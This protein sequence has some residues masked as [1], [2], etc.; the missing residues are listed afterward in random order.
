MPLAALVAAVVLDIASVQTDRTAI[1]AASVV[2]AAHSSEAQ[3]CFDGVSVAMHASR[4][5][6]DRAA[7][8]ALAGAADSCTQV[9]AYATG[10]RFPYD[11]PD[12]FVLRAGDTFYGYSTNSGAGDIQ[13]I[14][15][16]DLANWELVGNALAA[17]PRLGSPQHDVGAGRPA[18]RRWLRRVLHG[19]RGGIPATVHLAGGRCGACRAVPRRLERAA[20]VP[21]RPRGLDRSEPVRR[22]RRPRPHRRCGLTLPTVRAA[23]APATM[24]GV[25]E[26]LQ[27]TRGLAIPLDEIE[28]RFDTSGGPGGQHANRARTRV[29][30][31]F[32]VAA[33][34]SL[35][36]DQR[37]RLRDRL[38]DVVRASA[39]DERSQTRNRAVALDRLRSYLAE[40]LRE[41]RP[42]RATKPSRTSTE[43]R[44]AGKRRRSEVKRTRQIPS[45]DE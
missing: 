27:V 29:E 18:T 14:R 40:A 3:G 34:P 39:G 43:R 45:D 8:D 37:A 30:V 31:S 33:S 10:A 25:A 36:S 9:L 17:L 5:G 4:R 6:D 2:V 41:Q 13:V 7:V 44:L 1:D 22:R 23:R 19:P 12:P 38:G 15:S 28:W 11:F 26:T 24:D 32:D 16:T 42:R 20:R 21:A 35:T